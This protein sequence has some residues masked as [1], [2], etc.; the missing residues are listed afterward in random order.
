MLIV[1][2][3][4]CVRERESIETDKTQRR[5]RRGREDFS[6]LED[7]A[8]YTIIRGAHSERECV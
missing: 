3:R 6:L 8:L 4:V 1:R 2:E 7:T 5:V